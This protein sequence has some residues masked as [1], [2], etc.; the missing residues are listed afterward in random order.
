MNPDVKL[1]LDVFTRNAAAAVRYVSG[2]ALSLAELGA[3]REQATA[4]AKS[5]FLRGKLSKQNRLLQ[6]FNPWDP[7]ADPTDP[8]IPK[9]PPN[10]K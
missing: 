4:F 1:L 8:Y 3:I 6:D 7:D 2:R 9:R 10:A 5:V